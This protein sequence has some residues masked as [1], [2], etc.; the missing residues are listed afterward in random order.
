MGHDPA[1]GLFDARATKSRAQPKRIGAGEYD[2]PDGFH[3][4]RR[5]RG[6]F[7]H[8]AAALEPELLLSLAEAIESLPMETFDLAGY[9]DDDGGD[10]WLAEA[11]S[12]FEQ[13]STAI[14]PWQNDWRLTDD[15]IS[16]ELH[17]AFCWVSGNLPATE[18]VHAAWKYF[19][20][21]PI[22]PFSPIYPPTGGLPGTTGFRHYLSEPVPLLLVFRAR[23]YPQYEFRADILGWLKGQFEQELT[24]Y[25]DAVEKQ[26]K[27]AGLVKT[28]IKRSRRGGDAMQHFDWLV[29]FQVRYRTQASIAKQYGNLDISTVA[30]AL[31]ST[32]ELIG[33][34]RRST[35]TLE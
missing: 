26:M 16:E 20:R 35:P 34:T 5:S 27:A 4:R 8:R 17:S 13:F 9:A 2:T 15:W 29:L 28:P 3:I 12:Q 32:A 14:M 6:L 19:N 21:E 1:S 33:L 25:L 24:A 22:R 10:E 30:D 31:R 18:R 7:L 11:I 23:W